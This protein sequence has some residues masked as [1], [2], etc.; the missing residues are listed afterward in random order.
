MK[1]ITIDI[2]QIDAES[3]HFRVLYGVRFPDGKVRDFTEP[4][5]CVLDGN[6]PGAIVPVDGEY[7]AKLFR[8]DSRI[9]ARHRVERTLEPGDQIYLTGKNGPDLAQLV[10]RTGRQPESYTPGAFY[11]VQDDGSLLC[12]GT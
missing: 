4:F 6:R 3:N 7:A 12:T 1:T 11:Q 10:R 9:E 2:G 8:L 5:Y